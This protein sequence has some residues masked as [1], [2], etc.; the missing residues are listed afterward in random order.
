MT[1]FNTDQSSQ[2]L[3]DTSLK[4]ASIE[5]YEGDNKVKATQPIKHKQIERWRDVLDISRSRLH[6]KLLDGWY[7]KKSQVYAEEALDYAS[8]VVDWLDNIIQCR[9]DAEQP[10]LWWGELPEGD[11]GDYSKKTHEIFVSDIWKPVD[12]FDL[13]LSPASLASIL[14]THEFVHASHTRLNYKSKRVYTK[15]DRDSEITAE[16][17]GLILYANTDVA[18][19][20]VFWALADQLEYGFSC[21]EEVCAPWK[22]TVEEKLDLHM[23]LN[24]SMDE[25]DLVVDAIKVGNSFFE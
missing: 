22:W 6:I 13:T 8:Q 17:V 23:Y 12:K 14:L 5:D 1:N 2:A 11:D 25:P 16:M 15:K 24:K 10:T 9:K 3:C 18:D 20:N 7:G 4:R 19:R 21:E